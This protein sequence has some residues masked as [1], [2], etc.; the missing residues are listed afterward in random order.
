MTRLLLLLALFTAPLMAGTAGEDYQALLDDFKS[1]R[2]MDALDKVEAFVEDHPDYKYTGSAYY[3]GGNAGKNAREYERSETLYRAMLK[4][5][6]ENR[7]IGKARN[8]LVIVLDAARKLDECIEQC[9]TNL[10]AEPDSNH[11]DHWR[12]LIGRAHFRM[13]RFK[14]SETVLKKFQSEHPDSEQFNWAQFYLDRINPEIETDE[15]GVVKGYDGKYVKDVR[16]QKALKNLPGYVNEAWKTLKQTLGVDLKGAQ[17]IFDFKDKNW[18]RTTNRAVTETISVDYKPYTKM[19]FYTEHVA[20][21]DA[22]FKSRVIHELK[23]AAFRDV[24]GVSYLDLPKW[25]REGLA[26]YGAQQFDDRL[27]AIVGGAIFS[28]RDGRASLD[29]IDDP[30]HNVEDYLEDCAAFMWLEEQKQGGV[31]E[32]C[33]RLLKGED[34]IAVFAEIGGMEIRQALDA[35]AEYAVKLVEERFGDAEESYLKIREDEFTA[36]KEKTHIGWFNDT[37]IE[38]YETWLSENPDHPLAPNCRYRLGKALILVERYDDGR[39]RMN[40]VTTLDQI[41][42]SICDDAQYWICL[43]YQ[44]EG[45]PEQADQAFGVLLRDYSWSRHA[46]QLK[47]SKL[48]AGPVTEPVNEEE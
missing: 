32:Y 33:K 16:F 44:R 14:E 45:K 42:S 15:N 41:R 22:D 23:H 46:N 39:A 24:M 29:G 8:D 30:N 2:Y 3:I 9:N 38:R 36:R 21:S 25:V 17:V 6:P 13:W 27:P 1:K 35:A 48:P 5:H 11:A 26:V 7:H 20:L 12:Y 31:H 37:G 34:C 18:S 4:L 40:D 10:E 43:S 28:G 47:D 19:T